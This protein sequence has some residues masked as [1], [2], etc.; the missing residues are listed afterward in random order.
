MK[1]GLSTRVRDVASIVVLISTSVVA[2]IGAPQSA[3]Q[4]QRNNTARE[5]WQIAG[6]RTSGASSAS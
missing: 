6:R 1:Q 3:M 5:H 4:R 2:Q